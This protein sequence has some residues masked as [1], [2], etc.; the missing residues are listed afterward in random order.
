MVLSFPFVALVMAIY[1]HLAFEPHSAVQNPEKLY[2]QPLLI[3]AV[4]VCLAVMVSLLL[5]DLP[6]MYRVF[7]P[8]L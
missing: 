5:I 8:T 4:V 3:G 7:I 2:R 1:F 6:F